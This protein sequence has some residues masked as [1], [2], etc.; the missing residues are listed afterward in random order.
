M[1]DTVI[2]TNRHSDDIFSSVF[3][4]FSFVFQ[5]ANAVGIKINCTFIIIVQY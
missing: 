5:A 1:L 3:V 2:Q 4:K